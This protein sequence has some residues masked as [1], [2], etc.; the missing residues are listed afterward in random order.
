MFGALAGVW[1]LRKPDIIP[2]RFHYHKVEPARLDQAA[3]PGKR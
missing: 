1:V 3:R 2:A